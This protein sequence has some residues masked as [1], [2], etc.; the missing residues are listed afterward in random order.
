MLRHINMSA[1]MNYIRVEAPI[2]RS[3]LA[4]KTGLNKATITNLIGELVQRNFIQE[5]GLETNGLGRP[6]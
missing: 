4:K 6:P 5:V 1:I 3:M 2:S